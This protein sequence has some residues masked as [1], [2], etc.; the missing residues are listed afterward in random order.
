MEFY[1]QLHALLCHDATG[2]G[3]AQAA[4]AP[5]FGAL[6]GS[7]LSAKRA[8]IL[9]GFPVN[10]GGVFRGETDGPG[11]AA[12]LARALMAVDCRVTLL[13]DAVSLPMVRAAASCLAP[14]TKV[15][16]LPPEGTKVFAESLLERL[17]PT[18]FFT[19]ERPGKGA[20]GHFH[21][22][23]GV[24]IDSMV[25]DTDFLLPLARRLG[26]VTVAIGDGG[27]ELGMG[28]LSSLIKAHVTHGAALAAVEAA[29][30]TLVSGV[31][32]WWGWGVEA[33]LSAAT[34]QRLLPSPA[35]EFQLL[36]AV[37]AAGGVDGCTRE[38]A[39]SVDAQSLS[40]H[41]RLLCRIG[42]ALNE[43]LLLDDGRA[44]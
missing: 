3:L 7:L 33:L 40:E 5:D 19:I 14:G 22:M 41:Q 17:R 23:H 35:E 15:V 27:N 9:T 28:A 43:S 38:S 16:S 30:F 24:V 44:V 37:V 2:R 36:S 4:P 25:T 12:N 39:L 11:G 21:N 20:D 6:T 1:S 31:S 32:N 29:D 26:A 34:G 8:V 13:T 18:H 42:D 10:C